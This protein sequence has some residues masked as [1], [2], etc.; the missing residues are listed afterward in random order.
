MLQL[1]ISS[2]EGELR[3]VAG[4]LRSLTYALSDFRPFWPA[5]VTAV[6]EIASEAFESEGGST[7]AGA[8]AR[9]SPRYAAWKAQRYPGTKILERTGRLKASLLGGPEGQVIS[10]PKQLTIRST[11]PYGGFHQE[12]TPNMPRRAPWS[13]TDRDAYRI[14]A[15]VSRE[16]RRLRLSHLA[17]SGGQA[18]A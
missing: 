3:A 4:D 13:P 12:G 16:I 17:W 11:V 9:L 15:A 14:T 1:S 7:R 5:A 6:R 2:G 10:E 8:W 18:A